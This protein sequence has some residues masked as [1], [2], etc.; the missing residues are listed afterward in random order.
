MDNND[1]FT[2]EILITSD[3][4]GHILPVDYRTNELQHSGL[5][6]LATIIKRERQYAP[7][8]LLVDN[9]DLIQGTPLAYYAATA[10]KERLNPAIAV[11]N[12]LRYDAAVLGN[13]EFNYGQEILRKAIQSSAFPWL[14]AGITTYET[15]E[16]AFGKPY[17]VKTMSSGMK[18]VILGVT[19]HYIPNWENAAHLK[20][21][22]FRDA[23][24]TVKDWTARIRQEEKP[25]LLIVAYHGG[26]ERD[27]ATGE[28]AERLTG[29]NQAYAMCM[30]TEGIDVLITGHQ[31]RFITGE[32]NGVTVIQPGLNG[33][34][35]GK[36]SVTL[37]RDH[38]GLDNCGEK[39]GAASRR[40]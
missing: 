16:P 12:E 2:C 34:A 28:A 18:M 3:I 31:H 38:R 23:L 20:G 37:K 7:E 4:H 6:K 10:G 5:A 33:Q 25:D 29:E 19:T 22:S 8:L 39:G 24:D 17:I 13:H 11:L 1:L 35:I 15:N 26:F 36:I 9:G 40:R 30:E 27:L 14:S 21:L 32:V